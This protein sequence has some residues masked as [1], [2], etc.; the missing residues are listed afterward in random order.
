MKNIFGSDTTGDKLPP[1]QNPFAD[2]SGNERS[3]DNVILRTKKGDR[4]VEVELPGN[5]GTMTDFVVPVSPA[6]KSE[7]GR[8]PASYGNSQSYND[9]QVDEHYKD[10]P[11]G[12]SDREITTNL[13]KA[14]PE[15]SGSR[16][17]VETSLGVIE[18]EESAPASDQSY[19]AQMDH[20]KQLY[21][22]A[23]YEA[24]LL[25]IDDMLRSYPTDPKLY[26][27]R[28]TLFE[29][30]GR[31]D[32]ALKAWNQA[33][34]FDPENQSLHRFIERKQQKRSLASGPAATGGSNE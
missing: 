18:S 12:M 25:E 19:L 20:L 32:L 4:S 16:R 1:I 34:R 26:E 30:M 27:M 7:G 6:F 29:R 11:P 3:K 17:E 22:K 28:G 15:D 24:A 2:Y 14:A 21:K 10:H 13:S 5:N 33:Y 9:D 8:N 31:G 23:R